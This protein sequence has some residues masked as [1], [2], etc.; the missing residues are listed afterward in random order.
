MVIAIAITLTEVDGAI[1]S[2]T[3]RKSLDLQEPLTGRKPLDRGHP[4]GTG[5]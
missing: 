2:E 1:S 3:K 4:D 5:H